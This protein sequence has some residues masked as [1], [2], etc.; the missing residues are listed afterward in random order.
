MGLTDILLRITSHAP[1]TAKGSELT[2]P[3]LDNNFIV[4]FDFLAG[5]SSAANLS[6]Y[7]AGTVY[8]NTPPTYVSY[9]GNIYQFISGTPTSGVTPGTNPAIWQQVT[10]GALAHVQN[11]D[12]YLNQGGAYEVTAPSVF[13]HLN[14]LTR[15]VLEMQSLAGSYVPGQDYFVSNPGVATHGQFLTGGFVKVTAITNS[16]L[17]KTASAWLKNAAMADF[18]AFETIYDVQ[19]DWFS[20]VRHEAGS[21]A[22]QSLGSA[23][24]TIKYFPFDD[25]VSVDSIVEDCIIPNNC[26]TIYAT[27]IKRDASIAL[28]VTAALAYC[29]FEEASIYDGAAGTI[30]NGVILEKGATMTNS[31]S[32]QILNINQREGS[33]VEIVNACDVVRIEVSSRTKVKIEDSTVKYLKFGTGMNLLIDNISCLGDSTYH[34]VIERNNNTLANGAA[35]TAAEPLDLTDTEMCGIINVTGANQTIDN[36]T[37]PVNVYDYWD[38]ELRPASGITLIIRNTSVAAGNIRTLNSFG[39][40]NSVDGTLGETIKLRW[41]PTLSKYVQTANNQLS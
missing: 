37:P 13:N 22:R 26:G 5:L 8:S 15:T 10:I 16:I 6:P 32:S 36:I 27:I 18:G 24:S 41:N 1:L 9:S 39:V 11:T 7:N 25:G 19:N 23:Y 33:Q 4:L 40:S 20:E 2:Y 38:I 35:V 34:D 12:L 17:K 28:D 21:I 31:C 29:V 14:G 30:G 3:E